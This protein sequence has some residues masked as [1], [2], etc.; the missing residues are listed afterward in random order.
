[1]RCAKLRAMP[2]TLEP[3]RRIV[4][5]LR[6]IGPGLILTASIVGSGELIV[7]PKLAGEV[8]YDLLWLIAIGC[9][10]KVFVQIEIGRQTL[11]NQR[12]PLEAFD[13]MPGPRLRVSWLV[14]LWLMMYFCSISQVGGLVGGVAEVLSA[15]G[16]NLSK[17]VLGIAVGASCSLLLA[18]GRY[19]W[20]E[21]GSLV[22]VFIFTVSVLVAVGALQ[23]TPYRISA[24]DLASGFQ[25][26]LS[27]HFAT[28]FAALGIIGVGAAEL[29][30]YPYWCVEKGYARSTGEPDGSDAWFARARGWMRVMRVDAW[31]SAI[32]Y[33]SVT[34]AFYLLGAAVL[35]ARKLQVTDKGLID[36][37]A[38][39]FLGSLG[40]WSLWLFLLGAF[41]VLYSTA[42]AATA[43]NARL[44]A[45]ALSVFRV[46]VY[47]SAKER[48][49]V[50]RWACVLLPLYA[51]LLY[52]I[53]EK[54]V[55]LVFVGAMG[56]GMMLP[57]LA[58]AALYF[59]YRRTDPRLAPG[60][61]WGVAL[62]VS[63]LAIAA[64]GAYQI[65]VVLWAR[66]S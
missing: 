36:T 20:V 48:E 47:R 54:P 5:S 16:I 50:V 9:V 45:D 55:A 22:M 46:R 13:G 56:Q 29:I 28:A 42:F 44:A 43:S 34:I 15:A 10:V 59:R 24:H 14:W 41:F 37:L 32:V 21:L 53:W 27:G 52:C 23:W 7:T 31:V 6:F 58:G 1:M 62:W 17:P 33:T 4:D 61:G 51:S 2:D 64:A 35:Y 30:Y 60:R 65:W 39:L 19:R 38:Q 63:S 8:G 57:F 49:G 18:F 11:A 26:R 3:P 40:P 66:T 25:F 12:T